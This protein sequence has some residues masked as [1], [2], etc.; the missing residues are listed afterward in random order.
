M[1]AEAR[2]LP[3]W[4]ATP[5]MVVGIVMVGICLQRKYP[6]MALAVVWA[7]YI[8]GILIVTTSVNAYCLE[9]YPE[10]SG[11]VAAW[12]N[13]GRILGGF[14]VNYF[15]LKWVKSVGAGRALGI[16]AAILVAAFG[17]IVIL[18]VYGS[19]LRKWQGPMNLATN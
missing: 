2:L 17:I 14:V 7:L 1:E 19:R 9:S 15:E 12:I 16:Q 5:L 4:F 3:I 6:V 10:A 18:Q 13:E 11:E 8:S